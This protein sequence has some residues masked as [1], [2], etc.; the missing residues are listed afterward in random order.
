AAERDHPGVFDSADSPERDAAAGD[1]SQDV[2]AADISEP[3]TAA[4]DG[5]APVVPESSR[6]ADESGSSEDDG[7]YDLSYIRAAGDDTAAQ[8]R[9]DDDA[10]RVHDTTPSVADD[11]YGLSATSAAAAAETQVVPAEPLAPPAAPQPIFVQA[12]EPP[13]ELGN[14]GAAG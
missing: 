7:D 1:V 3:E 13:R 9:F 11:A 4:A 10:T 14:R 6:T 5:V 12:P 2:P 8:D